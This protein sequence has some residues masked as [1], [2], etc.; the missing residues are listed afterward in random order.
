MSRLEFIRTQWANSHYSFSLREKDF[1]RGKYGKAFPDHSHN[2][3][4]EEKTS[5]AL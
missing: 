4:T 3:K 5:F 1:K 2:G